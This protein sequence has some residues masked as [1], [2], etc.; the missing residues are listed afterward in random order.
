MD[1]IGQLPGGVGGNQRKRR[2]CAKRNQLD[3][4]HGVIVPL[5]ARNTKE[6]RPSFGELAILCVGDIP[7]GLDLHQA[8]HAVFV[9]HIKVAQASQA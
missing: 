4:I 3:V 8:F 1:R 2:D 6:S 9:T 7:L 5:T